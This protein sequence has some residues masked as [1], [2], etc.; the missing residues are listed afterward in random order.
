MAI[1]NDAARE[2]AVAR[3]VEFLDFEGAVPKTAEYFS[4]DVH[5]RRAANVILA[6][7]AADAIDRAGL[8]V[9]TDSNPPIPSV[10][11]LR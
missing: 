9:V 2:V 3:H 5:M 11:P 4:D 7:V 8:I 6:T 10:A 1:Y